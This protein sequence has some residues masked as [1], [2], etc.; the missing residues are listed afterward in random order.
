M[1]MLAPAASAHHSTHSDAAAA[2]THL[3]LPTWTPGPEECSHFH[4]R[5]LS[6]P[7]LFILLTLLAL[8]AARPFASHHA[9]PLNLQA[10]PPC[11]PRSQFALRHF[12]A[13]EGVTTSFAPQRI[14]VSDTHTRH[15][16]TLIPSGIFHHQPRRTPRI[17]AAVPCTSV[18]Q[19]P[20]R[21]SWPSA[22]ISPDWQPDRSPSPDIQPASTANQRAIR[23]INLD[24]RLCCLEQVTGWILAAGS[25][26]G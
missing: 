12:P 24:Q 10:I 7:M 20:H 4:Q 2:H 3:L 26:R 15:A 18:T 11:R 1:S 21:I 19:R 25:A 17:T 13:S 23:L 8:P 5:S 9:R 6:Y 16:T 14:N 22:T